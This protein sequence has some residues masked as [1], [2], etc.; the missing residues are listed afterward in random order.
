M[1][2]QIEMKQIYICFASI[3]CTVCISSD[4][5]EIKNRLIVLKHSCS[6]CHRFRDNSPCLDLCVTSFCQR[7]YLKYN[8]TREIYV[9]DINRMSYTI[10]TNRMSKCS[11]KFTLC[12]IRKTCSFSLRKLSKI[13]FPTG[14]S[15]VLLSVLVES[16]L[17]R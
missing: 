13:L 5:A 15:T 8:S 1:M 10:N 11:S 6:I 9:T 12:R 7:I 2:Q 16:E 3:Y 14:S 4:T 17:Y